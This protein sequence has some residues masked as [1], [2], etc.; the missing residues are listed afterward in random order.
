MELCDAFTQLLKSVAHLSP[1]WHVIK[2]PINHESLKGLTL[3]DY[4]GYNENHFLILL[5]I[6]GLITQHKNGVYSVLNSLWTSYFSEFNLDNEMTK[7]LNN[8]IANIMECYYV[9]LGGNIGCHMPKDQC[10][11]KKNDNLLVKP[12]FNKRQ[13]FTLD[14]INICNHILSHACS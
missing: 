14:F 6:A 2:S 8:D 7:Q 3:A 9:R 12:R 13:Q 10:L 1:W 4:I 11:S 5:E